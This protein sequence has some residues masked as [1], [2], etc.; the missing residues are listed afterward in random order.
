MKFFAEID[1]EGAHADE[2]P[3]GLTAGALTDIVRL[4]QAGMTSG[5]LYD[6]NG[7]RVG[8]WALDLD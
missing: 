8:A 6:G 7:N 2:D 3:Q 4:I 5:N 1:S